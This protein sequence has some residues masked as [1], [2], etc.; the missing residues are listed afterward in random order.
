MNKEQIARRKSF[1]ITNRNCLVEK[2]NAQSV[3]II[4]A[5]TFI[6]RLTL[7]MP[8]KYSEE[9]VTRRGTKCK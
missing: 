9:I 5:A 8:N 6:A 2:N 7:E 3:A 1:L 4:I